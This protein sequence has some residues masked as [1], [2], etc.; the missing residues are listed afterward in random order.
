[1]A[2]PGSPSPGDW[3]AHAGCDAAARIPAPNAI[4]AD[5]ATP[6]LEIAHHA[7]PRTGA[8][9]PPDDHGTA[10][11]PAPVGDRQAALGPVAVGLLGSVDRLAARHRRLGAPPRPRTGVR[12]LAGRLR[13]RRVLLRRRRVLRVH[14]RTSTSTSRSS[15]WPAPRRQQR[16]L[17]GGLRRRHLRLRRRRASTGR[18]GGM[19]LNKPIVGM[20][21]TPDGAG[22]G[23]WPPTAAIF[24][25][26]DAAF[27]GSMGGQPPQ[28]AR[29]W[30]WR[31]PPTAGATGW[32][33]PTAAS[34]PSVT[35]TS[36]GRPGASRL[37][38]PIV[39]MTA[40][41]NGAGYW[42]VASDGGVFAFGDAPFYG[43][44]GDVPQSRPIVAITAT[45]SGGG[46][47]FTNNNG[48]VTAFGDA[49]YWG[50][51]PQ[52]LN[53]P[54]GGHG[55]SRR[56]RPLHRLVVPVR[57]LRLRH[58]QLPVREPAALAPHHRPGPGGGRVQGA[59]N[60]ASSRGGVGRRWAQPLHLP[61]LRPDP[62]SGDPACADDG[63]PAGLQLRF[64]CRP[65]RLRQGHGG[66][67]QHL[68]RLVA[69]RGADTPGVPQW[70]PSRRAN[71]A[72]VKGAIDGLH[73]EGLNGV[74]IYASPG[75]WSGIVGRLPAGG[76]L[77]GGRLGHQPGTTCGK[78]PFVYSDL[79]T[80]P[81]QIVQYSSTELPLSV[82][83]G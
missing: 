67:G 4:A 42:F 48:A 46:Y 44:L 52:V 63:L 55:R 29:S 74:G 21:P 66:R 65:R 58:L 9:A 5:H 83:A 34:S 18:P 28:Q 72:V 77:L 1:M 51:A 71:A 49:T 36:T 22:T 41:P 7:L 78:R 17:A 25:F 2:R 54:G 23:W 37:N 26:G 8:T 79:P 38:K 16:L 53:S 80:G 15:A 12:L 76:A 24:A 19:A 70:S 39:G 6:P 20:A 73:F 27:Y 57:Q 43:S 75:A 56:Q 3:R 31:P 45:A 68:G 50:S 60:A 59:T 61:D 64:R 32:W 14:R 10:T 35:P 62:T 33:P 81:V 47:W 82:P 40:A 69:R 13:R 11:A 30:A